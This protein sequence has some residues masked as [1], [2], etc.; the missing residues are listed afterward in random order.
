M[1]Q[2]ALAGM[3]SYTHCTGISSSA[4]L[5]PGCTSVQVLRYHTMNGHSSL[6]VST[7]CKRP[8]KCQGSPTELCPTTADLAGGIRSHPMLPEY[9][10]SLCSSVLHPHWAVDLTTPPLKAFPAQMSERWKV[11]Q[12]CNC[13]ATLKYKHN[14]ELQHKQNLSR[15]LKFSAESIYQHHYLYI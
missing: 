6:E 7:S 3:S 14:L 5:S 10:A 13:R 1:G 12:E 11:H 2:G 15:G 9:T 4:Q 8:C